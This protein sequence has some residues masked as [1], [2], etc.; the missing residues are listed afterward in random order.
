MPDDGNVLG[1]LAL[2]LLTDSRRRARVD[3]SG[4]LVLLED[5][6]RSLWDRDEIE[7]GRALTRAALTRAPRGAYPLQAAIAALHAEAADASATDWAQIAALYDRLL[8]LEPSPVIALNRAVAVA[9]AQGPEAGLALMTELAGA[10]DGY[11]LFHAARADLERRA[12]DLESARGGYER[13]LSL[14]ENSAEQRLLRKKLASL[15]H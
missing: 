11:H 5:Q 3:A 7:E 14:C 4:D 2:M 1:L 10:L 9:M 12:G 6:D 13:A 8:S 15:A